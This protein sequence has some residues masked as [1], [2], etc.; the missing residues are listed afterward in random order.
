[1]F[2]LRSEHVQLNKHLNRIGIKKM[3]GAHYAPAQR[4]QLLTICLSAQPWTISAL[5]SSPQ[6]LTQRTHFLGT[7][8]NS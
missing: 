3:Q 2:R 7:E 6:T 4:N 8:S 5:N 1:M